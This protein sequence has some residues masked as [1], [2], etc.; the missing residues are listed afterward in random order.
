MS[1]MDPSLC[2]T[3]PLLITT[4]ISL[5][6]PSLLYATLRWP[7]CL[8]LPPQNPFCLPLFFQTPFSF[9]PSSLPLVLMRGK[10]LLTP[11][12]MVFYPLP[13]FFPS[14]SH[15]FPFPAS[16]STIRESLLRVHSTSPMFPLLHHHRTNISYYFLIHLAYADMAK[17]GCVDIYSPSST[18]S[19]HVVH[20][21]P[22]A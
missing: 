6:N 7:P 22:C 18:Y 21:V 14:H 1:L 19:P 15:S 2:L 12:K 4:L 13:L 3:F 11:C 10:I 20:C 8:S 17:C 16:T 9:P 5:L